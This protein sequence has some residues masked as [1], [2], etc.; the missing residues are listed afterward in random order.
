MSYRVGK[1]GF[2]NNFLP[3]YWLEKKNW[4]GGAGEK[5]LK[6]LEIIESPPKKFPE[7]LETGEIDF[8]PVPSFHFIKN[9]KSLKN[10]EFCIASKDK[11]LSVVVVSNGKNLDDGSIAI[12][13][14]TLTSVNLLKV[15][16]KEKGLKNR[17][18]VAEEST[19]G[20]LLKSCNNALVIGD[21]A[22][23]ARMVYR[24]VMD[25]GEEFH[26][27]TGYPMVFGISASLKEKDMKEVDRMI[28]ESVDWGLEHIEEVVEAARQKFSLPPE[29][30]REYFRTLSY[31]LGSKEKK[32]L[33]K[34]EEMCGEKGLL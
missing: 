1:F 26:E 23:K 28:M 16:L 17:L 4:G 20:K 14:A 6:S 9:K 13:D 30:L 34:F 27:I 32:G 22:I 3:Y 33:K 24:V 19:A 15:I 25:L 8:A 11:V 5:I 12:S 21:E 7:M 31:R 18:V 10:Y 29:F 2:L